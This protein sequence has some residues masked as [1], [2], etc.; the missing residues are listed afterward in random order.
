MIAASVQGLPHDLGRAEMLGPV[1]VME[2]LIEVREEYG[3]TGEVDVWSNSAESVGF[4]ESP[5]VAN[6]PS[7]SCARNIDLKLRWTKA[8][9]NLEHKVTVKK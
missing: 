3:I 1:I 9:E 7:R 8:Q 5:R 6:L 4:S 2:T